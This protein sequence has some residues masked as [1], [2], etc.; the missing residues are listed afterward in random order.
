M[1]L[2]KLIEKTS[3]F[4]LPL[5]SLSSSR[6]RFILLNYPIGRISKVEW[7]LSLTLSDR[8]NLESRMEIITVTLRHL[9]KHTVYSMEYGAT[10][11]RCVPRTN[12]WHPEQSSDSNSPQKLCCNANLALSL[13]CIL[14]ICILSTAKCEYSST[15][16]R[17]STGSRKQKGRQNGCKRIGYLHLMAIR[18]HVHALQIGITSASYHKCLP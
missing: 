15:F 7:K 2:Q 4:H 10:V 11:G 17:V 8:E 3:S 18:S 9:N 14:R 13:F 6:P 5:L 1:A 12:S 16:F